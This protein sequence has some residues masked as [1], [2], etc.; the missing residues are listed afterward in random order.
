MMRSMIRHRNNRKGFT[1]IE[2]IVALMLVGLLAVIFLPVFTMTIRL[3][4]RAGNRNISTFDYQGVT[5]VSI[6]GQRDPTGN[7][8]L[9][10]FGGTTYTI[11]GRKETIGEMEY[12]VP[13][14]GPA[15]WGSD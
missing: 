11:P 1:L 14:T 7:Q 9:I 10:E 4:T 2:I 5:E 13:S 15:G 8:L 12:F 6:A 3:I